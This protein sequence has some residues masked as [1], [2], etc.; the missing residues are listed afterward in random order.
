MKIICIGRNYAAH[1]KELNNPLPTELVFFLKPS[2]A[3]AKTDHLYFPEFLKEIHHEIELVL[4]ISKTGKNISPQEAPNY[5]QSITV[6]LDFTARNL[7]ETLKAKG[8]PWEKAKAFDNSAAVGHF[9]PMPLEAK[10]IP[11]S[12]I[13]N[14][15]IVQQ[16][17]SKDM[18]FS[19]PQIIEEVSKY[20]TLEVGDLIFT[21]TPSGVGAVQKGDRLEGFLQEERLLKIAIC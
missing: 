13:K 7:Q 4:K 3:L 9:V 15:S 11:F 12:L 6:G 18:I 1:A 17:N 19:L 8:L 5:Y 20:I 21:G 10:N 14:A 16:G 2:T